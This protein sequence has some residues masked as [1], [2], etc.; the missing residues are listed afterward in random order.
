MDTL[1][2][3][4]GTRHGRVAELTRSREGSLTIGRSFKNDLVLTDMHVAPRQ[5]EILQNGGQWELSVLDHTNPVHHNG[6]KIGAESPVIQSGDQLTVGRTKLLLFSEG[7]VVEHTRKLVLSSWL[8]RE[9]IN[10]ILPIV[11]LLLVCLFDFTLA[12]FEGSTTLTWEELASGELLSV[13]LIVVWAGVWAIS[14]RI[15]RHQYHFRL[16]VIATSAVFLFA[17]LV[18]VLAEYLAYPFHRPSA[19]ELIG[20]AV[21]FVTLSLLLHLNLVVATNIQRTV[22]TSSVLAGLVTVV[23][24]GFYLFKEPEELQYK[25]I[26]SADLKPP[27]LGF[28]RGGS[29]EDYFSKLSTVV[30]DLPET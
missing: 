21:F 6:K 4:S 20:W 12:Y 8:S 1:V 3:Q 27:I 2:I 10:P 19:D 28:Y 16:Q 18:G 7:H 13:V 25:P 14:G 11:I 15:V 22:L 24:Y 26:Y 9:S 30:E 5:I 23:A 17:S 29:L